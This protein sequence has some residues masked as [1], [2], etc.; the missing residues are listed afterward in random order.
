VGELTFS[1]VHIDVDMYEPTRDSIAFFYERT[2]T[3]GVIICDDYGFSTCP[4]ATRAIEE[5][6]ANQPEP[7][8]RAP[9]GQ[10]IIFKR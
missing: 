10:A 5:F 1:F 6:M 4:G 9:T 3:G 7:I 8:V 2:A